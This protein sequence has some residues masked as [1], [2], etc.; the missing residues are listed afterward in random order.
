M[1]LRS[2]RGC[3]HKSE[4]WPF[5]HHACAFPGGWVSALNS[6]NSQILKDQVYEAPWIPRIGFQLYD[7]RQQVRIRPASVSQNAY[8]F[9]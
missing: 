2:F 8:G 5:S 6:R 9:F 7:P 4:G 3:L 1:A